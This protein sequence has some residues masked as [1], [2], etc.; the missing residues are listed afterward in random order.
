MSSADAIRRD[1]SGRIRGELL[2]EELDRIL[3]STDASHYQIRPLGAIA[4]ADAA[5]VRTVVDYARARGIPI[6]ARGGGTG[7]AGQ[8]LGEGI[9]LDFRRHMNRLVEVDGRTA[10]VEPGI[11]LKT[12]NT[13]LAPRG[14]MFA[15]DPSSGRACTIGGMIATN[16]SG[17]HGLRYGAVRDHIES[18]TAVWDAP[19]RRDEI[20]RAVAGAREGYIGPDTLKNSSGYLLDAGDEPER[21]L[22]GAEGTL[23]IVTEARLKLTPLPAARRFLKI[24]FRDIE[25]AC[26]AVLALRAHNPSA[27]ELLDGTVLDLMRRGEYAPLVPRDARVLLIAE[28]ETLPPR[29]EGASSVEAADDK[30]WAARKAISPML[31]R[32]EG[33]ERSTRIIEDVA[34]H[35]DRMLDYVRALHATFERHD[36]AGAIFGHAGSGHLHVNLLMDPHA[37]DTPARMETIAGEIADVTLRLRGTLS[38]EHG[39]GLIRTPYLAKMFGPLYDAFVETKRAFDPGN[40]FNP[41]KIVATNDLG[42]G[43]RLRRAR[44]TERFDPALERCNGCGWCADYCPIYAEDPREASIPR[45]FVNARLAGSRALDTAFAARC[46]PCN[47]CVKDCP[48]GFDPLR[49]L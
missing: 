32:W 45:A 47:R 25:T 23:G 39:D 18:L 22:I 42:A 26:A 33:S 7:V 11:V 5:D 46:P 24:G 3:Y 31:E 12:L 4:P 15:P 29:V 13:A 17:I 43:A 34:V 36:V 41:G 2:M 19:D 28:F 9:I 6:T 10:R 49:L 44:G 30:A 38:G 1:L 14:L 40:L 20:S 16:A 48:A 21:L 35:P 27:I 8:A 37:A